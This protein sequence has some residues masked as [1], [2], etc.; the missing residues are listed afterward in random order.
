MTVAT[1][2]LLQILKMKL[3]SL[4]FQIFTL[5]SEIHTFENYIGKGIIYNCNVNSKKC[6]INHGACTVSFK[7]THNV[8][9][10]CRSI[11]LRCLTY[12]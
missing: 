6:F 12:T 9:L 8:Y 7:V 4:A 1:L 2:S 3:A 10:L 5:K 11:F